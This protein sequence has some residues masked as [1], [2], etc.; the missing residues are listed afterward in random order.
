MNTV[1]REAKLPTGQVIRIVRGDITAEQVDAIVNAA[2]SYLKHG[3]R[4]RSGNCA[5][6]WRVNPAGK[7]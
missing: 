6:G 4:C 3:G 1:V 2:N 7:R 5:K